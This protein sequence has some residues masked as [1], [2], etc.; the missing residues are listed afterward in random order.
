M[1]R[2]RL[3]FM[4]AIGSRCGPSFSVILGQTILEVDVDCH[5]VLVHL[6][7]LAPPKRRQMLERH[8]WRRTNAS[9]LQEP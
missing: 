4:S 3:D 1:E 9:S 6:A 5:K 8:G 2:S 7:A